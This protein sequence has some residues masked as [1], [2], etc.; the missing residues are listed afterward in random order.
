MRACVPFKML[1]TIIFLKNP[2]TAPFQSSDCK[3]S[4]DV[5]YMKHP[6]GG[7]CEGGG[8][9]GRRRSLRAGWGEYPKRRSYRWRLTL[10]AWKLLAVCA[11]SVPG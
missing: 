10:A 11:C 5:V 8:G 2:G 7:A 9:R 1:R 6:E 4:L 3:Y